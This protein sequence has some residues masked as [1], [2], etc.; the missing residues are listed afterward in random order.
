MFHWFL[1]GLIRASSCEHLCKFFYNFRKNIK[2]F[3][4]CAFWDFLAKNLFH[5]IICLLFWF[6]RKIQMKKI[7]NLGHIYASSKKKLFHLTI[8]CL[9]CNQSNRTGDFDL[10]KEHFRH[11]SFFFAF[12]NTLYCFYINKNWIFHNENFVSVWI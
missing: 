1:Y 4:N 7:L 9:C 6:V 11:L 10:W 3:G 5:I 8:L 2:V 12:F